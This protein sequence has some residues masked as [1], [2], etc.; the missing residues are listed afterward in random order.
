MCEYVHPDALL[1]FSGEETKAVQKNKAADPLSCP[2]VESRVT[3]LH[4]VSTAGP[5]G[6]NSR[7]SFLPLIRYFGPQTT[8]DR[9]GFQSLT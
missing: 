8:A 9:S 4:W 6:T 1:R 3:G 2:Q 7:L 5:Q